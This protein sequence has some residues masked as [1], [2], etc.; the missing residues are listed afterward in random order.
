MNKKVKLK[1]SIKIYLQWP[2]ILT[3]LIFIMNGVVFAIDRKAGGAMATFTFIYIVFILVLYLRTK[4]TLMNDLITFATQ[5]GQIQKKLL[6]EMKI[7]YAILDDDGKLL[8]MNKEFA[9]IV[10][11]DRYY[12][13]SITG[14]FPNITKDLLPNELNECQVS[15]EYESRD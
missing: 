2:L 1:G 8:W 14:L 12:R 13:K 9:K 7:P 11:K 4:N 6:L 10:K 3:I 15:F 5:Y